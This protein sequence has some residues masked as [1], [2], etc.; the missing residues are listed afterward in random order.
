MRV[1]RAILFVIVNIIVTILVAAVIS[2]LIL[3]CQKIHFILGLVLFFVLWKFLLPFVAVIYK[4]VAK[5]NTFPIVTIITAFLIQG[6]E[7]VLGIIGICYY[8]IK[9]G[10]SFSSVVSAIVVIAMSVTLRYRNGINY[11]LSSYFPK[12][13]NRL[14]IGTNDN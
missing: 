2:L 12:K 9:T 5:I 7:C 6:G 4:Q 3:L 10:L 14:G 1:I 11:Q 8:T 13:Y